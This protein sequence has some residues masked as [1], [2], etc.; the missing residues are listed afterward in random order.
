MWDFYCTY[1]FARL[2]VH[3]VHPGTRLREPFE[4][5]VFRWL[6]LEEIAHGVSERHLRNDDVVFRHRK[7]MHPPWRWSIA[8][9]LKQYS[10]MYI[11]KLQDIFSC[12]DPN[13]C[14]RNYSAIENSIESQDFLQVKCASSGFVASILVRSA[15]RS[16]E[17]GKCS[18]LLDRWRTV[19]K[20]FADLWAK[21][22]IPVSTARND[23]A[24]DCSKD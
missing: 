12:Y 17:D 9:N 6:C 21:R 8:I 20:K 1:D 23:A 18:S 10:Y 11:L 5:E 13:P 14:C 4:L 19:R 16:L 3:D 22:M 15:A 24:A 7:R 2:S